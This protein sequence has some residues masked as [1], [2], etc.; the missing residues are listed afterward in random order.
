MVEYLQVNS[1]MNTVAEIVKPTLKTMLWK[2]KSSM[3]KILMLVIT[4]VLD[5]SI[6]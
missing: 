4:L 3:F 6:F 5:L 2:M 1:K